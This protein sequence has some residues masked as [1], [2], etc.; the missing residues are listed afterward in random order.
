MLSNE[1][2]TVSLLIWYWPSA[3]VVPEGAY[4]AMQVRRRPCNAAPDIRLIIDLCG[5]CRFW[6]LILS[7]AFLGVQAFGELEFWLTLIKVR[8]VCKKIDRYV[9]WRL[10]IDR[11]YRSLLHRRH[12]H[13]HVG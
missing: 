8:C 5:T 11:C 10:P 1:Y 9:D 3:R 12:H 2:N 7:F 4:I 13:Q 6:L